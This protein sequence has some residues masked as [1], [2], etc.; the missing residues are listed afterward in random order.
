M[1]W[2]RRSRFLIWSHIVRDVVKPAYDS[3]GVGLS[4][5]IPVKLQKPI[6][7]HTQCNRTDGDGFALTA[8]GSTC[9]YL[10][11]VLLSVIYCF[12]Q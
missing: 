3:A 10:H 1:C 9:D 6:V 2:R 5:K 7:S 4:H 11:R 8:Q 12:I